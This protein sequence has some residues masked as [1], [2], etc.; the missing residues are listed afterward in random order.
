MMGL[1]ITLS[2]PNAMPDLIEFCKFHP[3]FLEM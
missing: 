3:D 2:I 1:N